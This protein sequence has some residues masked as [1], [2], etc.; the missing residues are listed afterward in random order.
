VIPR[1]RLPLTAPAL[2]RAALAVSL[3][4]CAAA[5]ALAAPTWAAPV[6]A[7]PVESPV[8]LP[9]LAGPVAPAEDSS[10]QDPW[11]RALATAAERAGRQ[12][13]VTGALQTLT[14]WD[15]VAVSQAQQSARPFELV[16]GNLRLFQ[17]AVDSDVAPVPLPAAGWFMVMGLLGVAGVRLS[18]GR[19]TAQPASEG[20]LFDA[21]PRGMAVA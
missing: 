10:P 19:P 13:A 3:C 9:S 2:R 21:S 15:F 6:P 4:A 17:L 7:T 16:E 12:A 11:G 20:P 8:G 5:P 1:C 18:R 14:L